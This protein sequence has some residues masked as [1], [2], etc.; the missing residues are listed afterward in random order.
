MNILPKYEKHFTEITSHNHGM[1]RSIPRNILRRWPNLPIYLQ[2]INEREHMRI[3][4]EDQSLPPPWTDDPILDNFRFTNIHRE[5]DRVSRDLDAAM[6][7][8]FGAPARQMV[9]NALTFRTFNKL[10]AWLAAGGWHYH[11]HSEVDCVSADEFVDNGGSMFSNAYVVVN[12]MVTGYRKHRWYMEVM[13][14]SIWEQATRFVQELEQHPTLEH[15]T[16]MFTSL[17]GIAA[18]LG[19]EF[20]LDMEMLG[21]F[22]PTDSYTWANPGPGA[23]R[24]LNFLLGRERVFRQPTVKFLEELLELY[25]IVVP[26]LLGDHINPDLFDMRCI[27]NGLCETSKY[28]SVLTTGRAKRLYR[29]SR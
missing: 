12:S 29:Q 1:N 18:F 7:E 15:A 22:E 24:G 26:A 3:R 23:R 14:P 2:Y 16:R 6:F 21:L 19:Y 27:E 8:H 28:A 25:D 5:D 4:R 9:Y 20:A 10:D 17:P 11:P 13:F